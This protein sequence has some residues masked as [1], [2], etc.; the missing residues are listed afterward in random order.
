MKRSHGFRA[1]AAAV[2]GLLT[3]GAAASANILLVPDEY[4]TIQD[5]VDA[6]SY[7]DEIRI[8]PGTY[9]DPTHYPPGDTIPAVAVL[10][11][12]I[13]LTGSGIGQ[14]IINADSLGR[15]FYLEGL[16]D[17]VIHGMTIQRAFAEVYGA[18]IL[19]KGSSAEIYDV[20]FSY[21]YDSGIVF[22]EGAG[23]EIHDCIFHHNQAKAGG[24]VD[25]G[26]GCAP[27]IYDSEIYENDAPFAAGMRVRGNATIE[28]CEIRDNETTGAVNVMGGGI[29]VVDGAQPT[30]S[31][32]TIS[33]NVCYGDGGGI[34]YM[35]EGTGG[36][37]T[38]C[39]IIGNTSTG[40]EGCGGG[41]YASGAAP[42]ISWTVIAGNQTTG[43]WSDGGG[44]YLKYSPA[45]VENCTFYGNGTQGEG[46]EA[47]NLGLK[48]AIFTDPPMVSKCI[49][50]F[51]TQ[52]KGIYCVGDNEP[53]VDCCDVYGNEGGDEI[54]GSGS[55]N[56]SEDPLFCNPDEGNFH[57]QEGSPCAPGN[58][59]GGPDACD[60]DLIGACTV[61]CES[62]VD[63]LTAA[64]LLLR[65]APNPARGAVTVSFA[66]ERDAIVDLSVFDA[67]GRKMATLAS[68]PMD[69]GRHALA[70][71]G[72]TGVAPAASGVYFVRL[73]AD[74]LGSAVRLLYVE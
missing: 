72:L 41:I 38:H 16:E 43:P 20:E 36:T 9:T 74:G 14:T 11:S 13:T 39:E 68:G 63:E 10:K 26:L 66:L 65:V 34:A 61:G 73:E 22:T 53:L 56:F 55:D 7:G 4:P 28:R 6:A 52:G 25:I 67:S 54:C 71:N 29:L 32:C 46:A 23:G 40:D 12:G 1:V 30:I 58:H 2:F 21:N 8:A 33:G 15:G 57:L 45:V 27:H 37:L 59:P 31:Y 44:M 49:I 50:A 17:V 64:H 70:W 69:A 19:M 24:G 5:A 51:S 60:G 18:A 3:L 47:G 62:G 35:G 42:Q 48:T